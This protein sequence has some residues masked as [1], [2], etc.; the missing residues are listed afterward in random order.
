MRSTEPD[1][2]FVLHHWIGIDACRRREIRECGF[3]VGISLI[4]SEPSRD[5]TILLTARSNS[6]AQREVSLVEIIRNYDG[7]GDLKTFH[8][9]ACLFK[10]CSCRIL[11]KVL[12][13][14]C[15]IRAISIMWSWRRSFESESST[16]THIYGM[17][18]WNLWLLLILLGTGIVVECENNIGLSRG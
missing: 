13:L 12:L 15:L 18:W 6:S 2:R 17:Q 16:V 10:R 11:R 9:F 14:L 5:S 1:W 4:V 7:D 3:D 8:R